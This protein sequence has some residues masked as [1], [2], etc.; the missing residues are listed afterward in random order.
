MLVQ[1]AALRPGED[2]L[3]HAAGSG[4]GSAALQIA[5]LL[6]ARRIIVTAGSAAKL[7]R[8]AAMGA[9]HCLNYTEED[10]AKAVRRIT[11]KRGVDVVFEHTGAATFPGSVR[12]LRKG[13]RLVTCGA[14][15]GAEV[16][17]DLR[18]LFFKEIS[19]LGSM[20][21]SLAD[22]HA[23]WENVEAGRLH[24]VVSE[25]FDLSDVR[26]AHRRLAERRSFGKVVLRVG[27]P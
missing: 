26:E 20:M 1:R 4:V 3:I 2:V 23:V 5:G 25:V 24:A 15:S 17:L 13:G 27:A 19:L 9:T 22:F 12:S 21:G 6:G 16:A 8:A 14:T 18:L 11:E 7:E 10:V